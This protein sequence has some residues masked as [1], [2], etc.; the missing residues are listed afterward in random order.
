L[1]ILF[2][3][4]TRIGD[5]VLSSG[6]LRHLIEHHPDA[7]ITIVCGPLAASLF[8]AVPRA[9]VIVMTK[10]PFDGHWLKLWRQIRHARW[11]LVVDLRRSLV[12]YF[13][14]AGERRVL[15][16]ADD[17]IH[18]VQYI[19]SVLNLPQPAAPFLY[20]IPAHHDAA[21]LLI[22]DG[23]PVLAISPVA[24]TAAKTWPAERF[25][26]V[27][28]AVTAPGGVCAGWRV[29]LF[30]SP[31]DRAQVAALVARLSHPLLIFNE[32]DL[33]VVHA[34]LARCGRFLGND[35]GLAHLAAAAG[36]PVLSLFGPT[37]PVRYAPWGAQ[38][39]I[40]QA[41]SGVVSHLSAEAV[42]AALG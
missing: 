26:E 36:I 40:L 25:A 5:A 20:T 18:R 4:H 32:P 6:V 13:I 30:G 14:R 34:A 29:A 10:A 41:P 39:R 2:I 35:S 9:R 12:S 3:T 42:I 8:A 37:D 31:A 19:S 15:G 28:A 1:E 21:R 11:D 24:A 7:R 27:A 38:S 22:P 17:S 16:P 23:A 33:L